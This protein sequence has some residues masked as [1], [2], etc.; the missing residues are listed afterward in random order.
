MG[1]LGQRRATGSRPKRQ[2]GTRCSKPQDARDEHGVGS[3]AQHYR[4][5]AVR[6]EGIPLP[7]RKPSEVS[8]WLTHL[9]NLIPYQRRSL[10]AG[11][12]GVEVEGGV[13]ST[14][15]WML[16]LQI[17][18][19]AAFDERGWA[20]P[21]NSMESGKI[22]SCKIRAGVKEGVAILKRMTTS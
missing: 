14:P 15:D 4:P 19:Q 22:Q 18:T 3:S 5:E 6:D 7:G 2:A 10:N 21:R 12:C 17:L 16:N 1:A 8:E 13:L 9:Y 11:K 20:P